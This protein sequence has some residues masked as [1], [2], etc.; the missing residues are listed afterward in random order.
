MEEKFFDNTAS[1]AIFNEIFTAG[2]S[3]L[4]YASEKSSKRRDLEKSRTYA[5]MPNDNDVVESS[6]IQLTKSTSGS[7][8]AR[9]KDRGR[10]PKRISQSRE[11]E[12]KER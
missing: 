12:K 8:F 3:D 6:D 1:R 11:R 9:S 10:R 7:I 4:M 5:R 2:E